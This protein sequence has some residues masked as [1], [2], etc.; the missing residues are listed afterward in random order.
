MFEY[1]GFI[2]FGSYFEISDFF[3]FVKLFA[4]FGSLYTFMQRSYT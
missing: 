1:F 4:F 2:L 3:E